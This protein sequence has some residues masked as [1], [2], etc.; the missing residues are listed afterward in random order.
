M[1]PHLV[2]DSTYTAILLLAACLLVLLNASFVAAE[3][4]LVKVRK[5]RLE[6]LAKQG[7]KR[8]RVALRCA[9]NMDLTLSS[10]Q[11]GI[12]LAS[13]GL[14]WIGEEA[15]ARVLTITAPATFLTTGMS[16]HVTAWLVSFFSVSL[17]HVVLGEL[18]PKSIAI[19]DAERVA[20]VLARPLRIFYG[21]S[22]PLI[23]LFDFLAGLVLS[24]S[25]YQKTKEGPL[26][27]QELKLVMKESRK[28]GVISSGEALII[29]RAFE[30]ADKRALDIMV[31]REKVEYLCT[32]RS[33]HEN[34]KLITQRQHTRFPLCDGGFD[35]IIGV[36][37][38]KD[39]WPDLVRKLSN[40]HFHAKCSEPIIVTHHMR[41]D[42]L[43]QLFQMRRA[44]QAIVRDNSGRNI[45]IVTLEDVLEQL[46]GFFP[47]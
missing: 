36:I 43:L 10:T 13:L 18:V 2:N 46:V 4:A 9:N 7:D 22:R 47:H 37:R 23:L 28:D 44:H 24:V 30:F 45:G 26:S 3:F 31:P 14:G 17:M 8:A 20:L 19:Q 40:E 27:E 33:I 15:V 6:E 42:H 38:T 25:G 1:L 41:Q 29:S 34:M 11:L 35:R 21:F 32:S 16:R 39:V 5:T 12:T